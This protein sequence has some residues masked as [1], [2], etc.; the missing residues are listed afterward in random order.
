[1]ID[2]RSKVISK[3]LVGNERNLRQCIYGPQNVEEIRGSL[4]AVL[5]FGNDY[6][7]FPV[8]AEGAIQSYAKNRGFEASRDEYT[9]GSVQYLTN[10]SSRLF[11]KDM[12]QN[13]FVLNYNYG[14]KGEEF[15]DGLFESTV[16]EVHRRR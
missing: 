12:T 11:I 14:V 2:K 10:E 13:V 5:I 8:Q 6:Q 16:R 7:L 3:V 4:P 9:E 1:V 15:H